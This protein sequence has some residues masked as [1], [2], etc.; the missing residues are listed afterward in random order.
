[1]NSE[2]ERILKNLAIIASISQNDKLCTNEEQFGIYCPTSLRALHRMWCGENRHQNIQRVRSVIHLAMET[3]TKFM[4]QSASAPF[5]NGGANLHTDRISL[6]YRRFMNSIGLT[7]QGL[8]NLHKTYRDDPVIMADIDLLIHEIN[9]F[10][11][12][13]DGRFPSIEGRVTRLT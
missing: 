5:S 7:V 3:A 6:N 2:E 11:I 12:L 4:E 13:M 1:M 10:G 8:E 9:D